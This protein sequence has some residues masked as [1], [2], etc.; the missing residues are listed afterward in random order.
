MILFLLLAV[1]ITEARW[2]ALLA[3]PS[4]SAP[5]TA[6]GTGVVIGIKDEFAYVLS[7]AHV[8]QSNLVELKFSSR[9]NYPKPAWFGNG[10]EVL[11]RW[12]DPDIAL[13]RFPHKDRDV[14]ILRLAPDWQRPKAFPVNALAIGTGSKLAATAVPDVV[15]AKEFVRRPGKE[16]AFFWRTQVPPEQGRSGGPLLDTRGRV[17]GI[18]AAYRGGAG[19]YA[20]H[21][22]ILAALKRDGYGWLI[23]KGKQ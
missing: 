3:C 19:Y 17:I 14:S 1:Q 4:V 6:D 11:A 7:A 15:L 18:A 23:D 16:P 2:A 20:H 21:D 9:A 22:E 8:A 13:I 12:P 10:A 5:G